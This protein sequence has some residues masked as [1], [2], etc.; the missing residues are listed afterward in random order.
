MHSRMKGN[1]YNEMKKAVYYEKSSPG[2]PEKL[3]MYE[4]MPAGL[5]VLGELPDA[6]RKSVAIVGAR[7]C[8]VYGKTEARRFGRVLASRGVQ[9]ISGLA[10]GVDAWAHQGALEGGGSTFAGAL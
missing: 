2:Y 10:C 4:R 3:K 9:I 1:R 7:A 6:A 8:S 5:Y